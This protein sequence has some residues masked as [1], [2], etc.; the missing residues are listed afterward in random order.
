MLTTGAA[1]IT[2]DNDLPDLKTITYNYTFPPH[3]NVTIG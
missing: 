1:S 3:I 2:I